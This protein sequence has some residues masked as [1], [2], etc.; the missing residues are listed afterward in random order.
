MYAKTEQ[1]NK[2]GKSISLYCAAAFAA[3]LT[4]LSC[5]GNSDRDEIPE[6]KLA[7]SLEPSSLALKKRGLLLT[8]GT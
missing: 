8:S 6:G 2:R 4:V 7:I 3:F 1:E 5:T